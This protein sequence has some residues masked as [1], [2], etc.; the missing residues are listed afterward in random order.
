MD[1]FTF[2]AALARAQARERLPTPEERRL[3]RERAGLSQA[4]IAAALGVTRAAVAQWE[5]GRCRP[6]TEY[7]IPYLSIL[8]RLAEHSV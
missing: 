8:D 1:H 6:R 7:L 5:A 3:L 4:D 2:D